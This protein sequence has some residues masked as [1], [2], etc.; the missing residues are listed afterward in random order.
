MSESSSSQS[1]GDRKRRRKQKADLTQKSALNQRVSSTRQQAGESIQQAPPLDGSQH[2]ESSSSSSSPT[3]PSLRE[4]ENENENE[5]EGASKDKRKEDQ[6]EERITWTPEGDKMLCEFAAPMLI[7]RKSDKVKVRDLWRQVFSA[8]KNEL[9]IDSLGMKKLHLLTP[10]TCRNR[11]TKLLVSLRER[12][13]SS[14]IDVEN[15]GPVYKLVYEFHELTSS[16]KKHYRHDDHDDEDDEDM[17]KKN[18]NKYKYKYKYK[19]ISDHDDEDDE[20]MRNEEQEQVQVQVQVQESIH[21]ALAAP[22]AKIDIDDITPQTADILAASA[23]HVPASQKDLDALRKMF[24]A[25][26][27]S[28]ALLY[29]SNQMLGEHIQKLEKRVE[30]LEHQRAPS[31]NAK[32]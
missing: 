4:N 8:L 14:R 17:R 21:R 29:L 9:E 30:Q 27:D 20:D 7:T 19:K 10:L 1:G 18:K 28:Q 12:M 11:W 24:Q 16:K 23:S 31:S 5:E 32:K 22:S 26:K 2:S 3:N 25:L 13:K 6:K 15:L